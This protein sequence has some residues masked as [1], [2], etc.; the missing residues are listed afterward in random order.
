MANGISSMGLNHMSSLLTSHEV[1]RQ[2]GGP[3]GPSP[4]T[5]VNLLTVPSLG[6]W[7]EMQ[8]SCASNE[9]GQAPRNHETASRNMRPFEPNFE[10]GI[11]PPRSESPETETDP[12]MDE[13]PFWVNSRNSSV[14]SDTENLQIVDHETRRKQHQS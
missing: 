13:N 2:N 11:T 8:E 5:P 14:I 9:R 6:T 3:E 1:R 7:A 12:E 10:R 4:A